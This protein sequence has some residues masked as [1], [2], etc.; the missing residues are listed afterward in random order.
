[1][2]IIDGQ[3]V[4]LTEA[5]FGT[6]RA[7]DRGT[8]L[9][10]HLATSVRTQHLIGLGNAAGVV[11]GAFHDILPGNAFVT[12]DADLLTDGGYTEFKTRFDINITALNGCTSFGANLYLHRLFQTQNLWWGHTYTPITGL[13]QS[14][15]GW[16]PIPAAVRAAANGQCTIG[17]LYN[18][19]TGI[20]TVQYTFMTVTVR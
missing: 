19:A 3:E 6:A 10:E 5:I 13:N 7:I 8:V 18:A 15:S 2:T 1:M 11:D 4:G 16:Q 14:D 9:K 17:Y 12:F 20:P